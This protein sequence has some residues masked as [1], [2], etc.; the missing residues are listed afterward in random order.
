VKVK[1]KMEIVKTLAFGDIPTRVMGFD[2]CA[3][4]RQ[5]M[6]FIQLKRALQFAVSV[7]FALA[8]IPNVARKRLY[9]SGRQKIT[10]LC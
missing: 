1:I 8:C 10:Q 9:R 7:C 6:A 5:R 4:D 2:C 3:I